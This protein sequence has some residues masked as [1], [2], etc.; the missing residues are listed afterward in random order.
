MAIYKP[1]EDSYLMSNYLESVLPGLIKENPDLKL[2]E[3]GSG[4]GI[5]LKTSLNLG[6]KKENIFATDINPE[7]VEHC[8]KL[9]F[10]CV[11]SDLFENIKGK[12]DL[13]V[14]NPP[15][16]PLDEKEPEESRLETTGG[17]R[18]NELAIRF[19]RQAKNHLNENGKILL[20]TSSL[21]EEIDFAGL[22]FED[23]KVSERKLFHEKLH[24]WLLSEA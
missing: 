19:L 9:G 1:A 12:F 18:G 23:R 4:S 22:G 16:L 17:E 14:F 11:V 24:L 3:I 20:I 13:I 2:L 6:I 8:K 10:K 21:S 15:Y 7:A 5:Q